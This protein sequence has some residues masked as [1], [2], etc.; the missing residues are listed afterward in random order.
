[1]KKL[2]ILS[3]ATMAVFCVSS[4]SDDED[5]PKI[6]PDSVQMYHGETKQLVYTGNSNC[7]WSSDDSRIASVTIDG[8]V[9]A[10][11]IGKTTIWADKAKCSV[12]VLP[13]YTEI[14]LPIMNWGVKPNIVI[15]QM[16]ANKDF[17]SYTLESQSANELLYSTNDA[18]KKAYFY[19][20]GFNNYSLNY[21]T[22]CSLYPDYVIDFVLER[23][24]YL[25]T[26]TSGEYLFQTLD[27]KNIVILWWEWYDFGEVAW[28]QYQPNTKSATNAIEKLTNIPYF[29]AKLAD[30]TKQNN[31]F[32]S[33]IEKRLKIN[34]NK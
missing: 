18:S 1:M 14:A 21:V 12:E 9:E 34:A 25:G 29:G 30:D 7:S 3:L 23:Y 2:L 15:E 11:L 5:A 8:T 6:L 22:I 20:Y 24:E 26:L 17:I 33:N 16:K 27:E 13:Y 19:S 28:L 31:T 32:H 10:D 4:C